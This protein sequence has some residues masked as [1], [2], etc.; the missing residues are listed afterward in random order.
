MH[1]LHTVGGKEAKPQSP[2]APVVG[3]W[4][5]KKKRKKTSPI[6]DHIKPNPALCCFSGCIYA[7]PNFSLH[8][9]SIPMGLYLCIKYKINKN[10]NKRII[11]KTG[12][13]IIESWV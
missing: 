6:T 7:V 11:K 1:V 12:E 10:N 8:R 5:T 2:G 13:R 4:N 3:L 9:A